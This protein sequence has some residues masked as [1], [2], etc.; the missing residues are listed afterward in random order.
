MK[1]TKTTTLTEKSQRVEI[2]IKREEENIKL[3]ETITNQ[4]EV[5]ATPSPDPI[6]KV[7]ENVVIHDS[8]LPCL[9]NEKGLVAITSLFL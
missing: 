8:Q 5:A 3:N 2:C 7:E 9:G 6:A 1:R 4:H